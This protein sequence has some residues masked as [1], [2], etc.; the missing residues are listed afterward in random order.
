MRYGRADDWPVQRAK[1]VQDM[2]LAKVNGAAKTIRPEALTW[3]IVGD[4]SK[5]EAGVRDLKLGDVKV[6]DADGKVIR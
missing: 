1:K 6:L 3:I 5:I 4:L 2:T